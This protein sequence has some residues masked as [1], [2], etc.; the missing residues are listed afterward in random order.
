MS[1]ILSNESIYYSISQLTKRIG[2]SAESDEKKI[3]IN[4]IPFLYSELFTDQYVHPYIVVVPTRNETWRDILIR[5]DKN[6]DF[7]QIKDTI[8]SFSKLQ[9]LG[10]VPVIFWGKGYEEGNKPFAERLESGSII[11]Y[12]DII[13][14]TFFMLSR[15]EETVVK[16][17]DE[18]NRFP[19]T[20]S[21]AY[22]QGFLDRPIVDEYAMILREWI[23]V[24]LPRWEPEKRSFTIK[25]S[26]DIDHIRRFNKPYNY[27]RRFGG[28]LLK[29]HDPSLMWD[30]SKDAYRQFVK[31]RGSYLDNIYKLAN[32]S[33]KYNFKESAFYF[34]ANKKDRFG[35]G[36]DP[37]DKLLKDVFSYLKEKELEIGFHPGYETYNDVEI[38]KKEKEKLETA[39]GMKVKGGRQHYLRFKVPDTWRNWEEIG[40]EY[41]STMTYADHEG[42][43]CGTCHPFHPYDIERD[44]EMDL[45]E[46]PL[47]VMDGKLKQYR[48]MTAEEGGK[49]ILELAQRCK[50]VEGLFT[51]LWHNTSLDNDWKIWGTVY[52]SIISRLCKL[53]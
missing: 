8:P 23:K 38:L 5:D 11:F 28:D 39:L 41:D 19:A 53:E 30:T 36:Y 13:A 2:Y 12:A 50:D 20:A 42:F 4:N 37:G 52:E 6:L 29:R 18:H 51:L 1:N 26:H 21:V 44:R 17:R 40:M 9:L 47:V 27:I 16:T 34:M 3:K 32:L 7:L 43:R 24:L 25:L 46:I 10:K 31:Q 14:A 48:G 22:K 45:I 49:R 15:W 35:C 33:Q